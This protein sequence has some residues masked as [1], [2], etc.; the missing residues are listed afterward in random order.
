MTELIYSAAWLVLTVSIGVLVVSFLPVE[1]RAR[2]Y[3]GCLVQGLVI[4]VAVECMFLLALWVIFLAFAV[5]SWV[6]MMLLV[7]VGV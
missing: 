6:F 3:L 4:G 7:G 5:V 1:H 2:G